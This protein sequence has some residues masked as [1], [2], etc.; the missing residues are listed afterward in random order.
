MI[1]LLAIGAVLTQLD[2][3]V[4]WR[5][6]SW[7]NQT[8]AMISLWVATAYLLKEQRRRGSS[9]ITALPAAFMSAVSMTYILMAKEGLR[10]SENVAYP[11]GICFAILVFAVYAVSAFRINGKGIEEKEK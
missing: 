1:P 2:F 11:A 9:L 6:F 7:S 10:L 8:L 3:N 5:C 4:L